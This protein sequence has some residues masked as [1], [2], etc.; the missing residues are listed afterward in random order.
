MSNDQNQYQPKRSPNKPDPGNK[1][2]KNIAVIIIA[3]VVFTLVLNM[4]YTAVS[5]A[6]LQPLPR[7][8]FE[9]QLQQG[10]IKNV[11]FQSDRM[12][13]LTHEEA[14]KNEE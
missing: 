8:E 7:S 2:K 1:K 4:V 10:E 5:N 11:E 13:I 12:L 6:Y 9:Q 3:A 14:K